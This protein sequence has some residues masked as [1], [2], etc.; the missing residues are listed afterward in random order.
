M[1]TQLFIQS[2]NQHSEWPDKLPSI[3]FAM[4]S[5]HV[6]ATDHSPAS[7]SAER[8]PYDV[9]YDVHHIIQTEAPSPEVSQR[10]AFLDAREVN[11]LEQ[12]R[13]KEYADEHRAAGPTNR[14]DEKV[15]INSHPIN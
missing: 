8:T 11:E 12:D 7:F 1:T 5:A 6:Q 3:R 4:N 13:R 9:T 10:L 2:G 14:P 15:W